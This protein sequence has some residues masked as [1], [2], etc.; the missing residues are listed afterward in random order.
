M[1]IVNKYSVVLHVPWDDGPSG[2]FEQ[3]AD[4]T[5]VEND[6][7]VLCFTDSDGVFTKTSAPW[8]IRKNKP[9]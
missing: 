2:R 3:Y 9:E 5:D 8:T 1:S 4:C 7:P 6:G